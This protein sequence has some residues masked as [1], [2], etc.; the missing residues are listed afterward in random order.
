[1][2]ES[3]KKKPNPFTLKVKGVIRKIPRGKVATYRQVAALAGKPHAARGVSW[4][5]NSCSK[6]YRLPW[7]RVLSSKGRIAFPPL[8]HNFVMQRRLLQ[9]EGVSAM[10]NGEIDM[11]KHQWKKKPRSERKRNQPRMFS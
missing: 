9:R 1:M 10:D 7:H 3:T 5:L 4:I 11:P 8:T 6:K 2:P